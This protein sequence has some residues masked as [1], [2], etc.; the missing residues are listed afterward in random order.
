MLRFQVL[1]KRYKFPKAR[2]SKLYFISLMNQENVN[3]FERIGL[4][5]KDIDVSYRLTFPPSRALSFVSMIK[6][7]EGS[8][9]KGKD[10]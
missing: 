2:D 9:G 5:I 7:V 6:V 4:K 1:K 3:R 10:K 8:N